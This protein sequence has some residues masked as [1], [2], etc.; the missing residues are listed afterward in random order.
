MMVVWSS[1]ERMRLR[2]AAVLASA[3]L[4]AGCGTTAAEE[5]LVGTREMSLAPCDPATGSFTLEITN[6]Y[7]P[8]LPGRQW[9][10][11]GEEGSRFARVQITVLDET[12]VVAGVTTRVVEEREWI[13]DNI[14]EVSRNFV[15]QSADG[16]V[17]YFGEE[18]D[19]YDDGELVGHSGAWIAGVDGAQPGILMPG[20]PEVGVSFAQ[21]VAPGEAEDASA[22]VAIGDSYTVPAGT[23]DDT[24][25]AVD[26]DPIGGGVDEKRYARGVGLIV[27]EDL[28]LVSYSR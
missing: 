27:D 4:L 2:C 1:E 17:C 15:V 22:I 24:L 19:D 28:Q 10:L 23:F 8:F 5:A 9:V 12:R 25:Q 14:V 26:V 7:L 18:V 13:D 6:A 20:T 11:E 3:V 16:S 21:E